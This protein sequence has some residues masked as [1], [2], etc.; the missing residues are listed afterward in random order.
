MT[1][2]KC[3]SDRW[4]CVNVFFLNPFFRCWGVSSGSESQS[5]FC[6]CVWIPSWLWSISSEAKQRKR[7][8]RS[9]PFGP[10]GSR[11]VRRSRTTRRDSEFQSVSVYK[12]VCHSVIHMGCKKS[13]FYKHTAGSSEDKFLS[14]GLTVTLTLFI[15][16]SQ[17][18][19]VISCFHPHE[20]AR[21]VA[22]LS[23]NL[24]RGFK[25]SFTVSDNRFFEYWEI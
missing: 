6:L 7:T 3:P 25:F 22:Q 24:I 1:F 17:A 15:K 13:I 14:V 11:P 9:R 12:P 23:Q 20:L 10:P 8:E 19:P 4:H 21:F 5:L 16:N 2:S 18:F